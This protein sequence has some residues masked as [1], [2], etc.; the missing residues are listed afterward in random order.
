MRSLQSN[1][2]EEGENKEYDDEMKEEKEEMSQEE[3]QCLE[4][5]EKEK[6]VYKVLFYFFSNSF[7]IYKIYFK[8]I[9]HSII[10]KSRN[11]SPN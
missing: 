8:V 3:I 11:H 5:M 7:F 6:I 10:I 9:Y 1:D 2:Q 4:A